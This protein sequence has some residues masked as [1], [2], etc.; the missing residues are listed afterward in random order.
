M[1]ESIK[2]IGKIYLFILII[3]YILFGSMYTKSLYSI[4]QIFNSSI[5]ICCYFVNIS[6]LD[7]NKDKIY[8]QIAMFFTIKGVINLVYGLNTLINLNRNFDGNEDLQIFALSVF[9]EILLLIFIINNKKMELNT[10][11]IMNICFICIS[12]SIFIICKTSIMPRLYNEKSVSMLF[13]MLMLLF[14]L[15]LLYILKN[16]RN[17]DNR[18]SKRTIKDL[19]IYYIARIINIVVIFIVEILKNI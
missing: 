11:R 16:L 13:F 8:K 3:G 7:I 10:N 17:L 4:I 19:Q 15:C 12:I 5:A 9:I 18:L 2:S 6:Y 14:I 1:N